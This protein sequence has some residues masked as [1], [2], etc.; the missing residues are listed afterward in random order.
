[1]RRAEAE[2]LLRKGRSG[3]REWNARRAR[4]RAEGSI[5]TAD[6]SGASL[7]GLDLSYA[8]FDEMYME[9]CNLSNSRLYKANF[10]GA[11]LDYA[12]LSQCDLGGTNFGFTA[13]RAASFFDAL[14]RFTL[15]S[16]FMNGAQGLD[17]IRHLGRSQIALQTIRS[18]SR[19]LPEIFLRGCGLHEAEIEYFRSTPDPR[20]SGQREFDS[21]F[22]SYSTG[23]EKFA[24][25]LRDFLSREGVRCW[26]WN[27]KGLSGPPDWGE[28]GRMI[29]VHDR[30]L[31]L[32]SRHSL[33]SPYVLEE[34]D[35]AL[36]LEESRTEMEDV[37]LGFDKLSPFVV[38][39]LDEAAAQAFPARFPQI[40]A[41]AIRILD[42]TGRSAGGPSVF[43]RIAAAL[44]NSKLIP[45]Y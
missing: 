26:K 2:E 40:A 8:D 23:D 24:T 34:I 37:G 5:L 1:M 42:E 3:V 9:G 15:M 4:A 36:R 12:D 20:L 41:S 16:G 21:C 11:D 31:L 30:F 6:F 10:A 35:R 44:E 19:P 18:L 38:V 7:E 28:L 17:S 32:A 33:E 43:S 22:I 39:Y 13:L 14:M 45:L 27:D 25:G 29:N